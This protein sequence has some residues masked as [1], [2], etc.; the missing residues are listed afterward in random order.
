MTIKYINI[1]SSANKGDGD[2]L[3]AAFTKINDNFKELAILIGTPGTS[4]AEIV[5]DIS[6]KLL[7]HDNHSGILVTYDEARDQIDFTVENQTS[8]PG[9]PISYNDLTDKPVIPTQYLLPFA[10]TSTLGGVIIGDGL[11]IDRGV[12]SVVPSSYPG[13]QGPVGSI[14]YKNLTNKP[15][16]QFAFDYSEKWTITHQRN[17]TKIIESIA[18]SAGNKLFAAINIVDPNSFEVI[19]TE[20]TAGTIN[21]FFG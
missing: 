18:D 6:V 10:T 9:H 17:T 13:P 8:V 7:V 20:A 4:L 16:E 3:R 12:L 5:Q 14:S 19:F 15:F 1:G 2:S 11:V 21:V